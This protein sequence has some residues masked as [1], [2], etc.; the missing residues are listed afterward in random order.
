[1]PYLS[2]PEADRRAPLDKTFTQSSESSVCS[3]DRRGLRQCRHR[4]Q[5]L[6]CLAIEHVPSTN[7][8]RIS[9]PSNLRNDVFLSPEKN[10]CRCALCRYFGSKTYQL[11]LK[12]ASIWQRITTHSTRV[13]ICRGRKIVA[14]ASLFEH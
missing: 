2:P 4:R 7:R 12:T 1:M 13:P 9:V 14:Q 10:R 11:N 6:T 5:N 8:T 3:N